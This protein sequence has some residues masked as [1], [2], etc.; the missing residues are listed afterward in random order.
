MRSV[1]NSALYGR[2]IPWL[3]QL[4]LEVFKSDQAFSVEKLITLTHGAQFYRTR[5]TFD[6]VILDF[7]AMDVDLMKA[8]I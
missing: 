6:F 1:W 7:D 8:A 3:F 2:Q 4:R 5:E